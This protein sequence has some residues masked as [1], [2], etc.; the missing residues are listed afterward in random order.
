MLIG[1]E[2]AENK[3]KPKLAWKLLSPQKTQKKWSN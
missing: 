1:L 3:T 2:F